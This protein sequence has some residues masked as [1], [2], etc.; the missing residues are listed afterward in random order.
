MLGAPR[1]AVWHG[2]PTRAQSLERLPHFLQWKQFCS[3]F[4]LSNKK[5]IHVTA[6]CCSFKDKATQVAQS[7]VP[8]GSCPQAPLSQPAAELI[9]QAGRTCSTGLALVRL[10]VTWITNSP[11]YNSLLV[12]I[13]YI[14]SVGL[15][16]LKMKGGSPAIG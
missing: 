4:L 8:S 7:P 2:P 16:S 10:T 3:S 6:C 12:R 5:D 13:T 15:H 1:R 14:R 11:T 9:L